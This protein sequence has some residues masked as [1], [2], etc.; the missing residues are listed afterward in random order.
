VIV[1]FYQACLCREVFLSGDI[2]SQIVYGSIKLKEEVTVLS[3]QR[4]LNEI[5]KEEYSLYK[6]Y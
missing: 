4:K 1:Y 6:K 5:E 3:Y 2:G